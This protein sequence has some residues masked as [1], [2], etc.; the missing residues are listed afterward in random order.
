M[1]TRPVPADF[2]DNKEQR[3]FLEL[4]LLVLQIRK[5]LATPK[6]K[7]F[8]STQSGFACQQLTGPKGP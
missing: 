5:W 8:F 6:A 3:G 4:F 2:L 7:P 1:T